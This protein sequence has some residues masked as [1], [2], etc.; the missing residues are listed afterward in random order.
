[1][2]K[3][4]SGK[5]LKG[6]KVGL[7]LITPYLILTIVFWCIPF[8]WSF[9]LAMQKWNMMSPA[10]YVGLKNF[11]KIF[12]DKLFFISLRNTFQFIGVF[13]PLCV[14]ISL[15]IAWTIY[16][17]KKAPSFFLISFLLPYVT[18]GVAYAV[19]FSRL[20]AHD[21][22]VNVFLRA[23]NL[24]IPFFTDPRIAMSSIALLV[25]WKI[26]GYYALIFYAGLQA[27]PQSIYDAALIDGATGTQTFFR[28]TIPML[29]ASFV[30]ILIFAI[31][32]SV[33][34]FTEPFLITD[35]GPFFS[36][37]TFV[38]WTYKTTFELLRAG[39][40]SALAIITASISFGLVFIVRKF[41][42][43]EVQL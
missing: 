40:G 17:V 26:M 16:K 11:I 4:K 25:V 10:K 38:F 23:I 9:I 2:D 30:T 20:F 41:V 15:L 39:Q 21:G 36:T 28:V 6:G 35:G 18:A 22:V 1:M 42:E 33:N 8:A 5:K 19:I 12:S 27:I 43:K 37:H 34:I 31:A 24:N 3:A 7:A 14:A 32:L 13:I 29:N